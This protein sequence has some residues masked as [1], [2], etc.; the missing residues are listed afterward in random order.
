MKIKDGNLFQIALFNFFFRL[1][2]MYLFTR[3]GNPFTFNYVKRVKK[4]VLIR[5]LIVILR[6]T[7]HSILKIILLCN[8]AYH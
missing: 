5:R 7:Y 6:G 3:V 4:K 8:L 1:K 2:N